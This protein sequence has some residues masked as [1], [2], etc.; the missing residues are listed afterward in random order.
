MTDWTSPKCLYNVTVLY[1]M[2]TKSIVMMGVALLIN[3]V[4]KN[5]SK[6]TEVRLYITCLFHCRRCFD[7][8]TL[9]TRQSAFVIKG[10]CGACVMS[11]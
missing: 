2:C 4:G 7:S 3:C 9:I 10:R 6:N 1:S 11:L 5:L 8:C